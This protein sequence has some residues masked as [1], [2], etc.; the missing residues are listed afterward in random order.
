MSNSNFKI[1]SIILTYDET[2]GEEEGPKRQ[3]GLKFLYV[4]CQSP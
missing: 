4:K 2:G 1:T 3:N